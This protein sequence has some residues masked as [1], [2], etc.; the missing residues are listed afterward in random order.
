MPAHSCVADIQFNGIRKTFEVG[1]CN[2]IWVSDYAGYG[3]ALRRVGEFGGNDQIGT[4]TGFFEVDL[5]DGKIVA[6]RRFFAAR[7]NDVDF[8]VHDAAE[9]TLELAIFRDNILF[10]GTRNIFGIEWCEADIPRAENPA[11]DARRRQG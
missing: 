10:D 3:F 9:G 6:G 7:Y 1:R 11:G 4:V 8:A 2:F 5:F